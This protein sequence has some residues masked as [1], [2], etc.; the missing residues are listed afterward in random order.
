MNREKFSTQLLLYFLVMA[1]LIVIGCKIVEETS[2]YNI[3]GS[4]TVYGTGD[5]LE[6]S[7][8]NLT[9]ASTASTTTDSNGD[10]SFTG[11]EDGTYTIIPYSTEYTFNP[12]STV[13]IVNGANI[14]NTN[15]VATS[16][17]GAST[18]SI[19]GTVTGDMQAGVKI[20]LG[21]DTQKGTTVT[22]KDGTYIFE[23]LVDGGNYTVTPSLSG[24]TFT[25]TSTD[26][27]VSGANIAYTDFEEV[28][29]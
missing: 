23:N 8:V 2:I 21:G 13:V 9:S 18:Y 17:G 29:E 12:V 4:V 3:S 11:Q 26:V 24:Y 5:A 7:T 27:T 22:T 19:S 14:T 6:G 25:P 20:T 15:F 1:V 10:F 28:M 16:T